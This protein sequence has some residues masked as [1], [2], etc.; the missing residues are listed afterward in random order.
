MFRDY[1]V[2]N[3]ELIDLDKCFG[4]HNL[5]KYDYFGLI[6]TLKIGKVF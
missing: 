6:I 1:R 2:P 3:N 4:T 5:D